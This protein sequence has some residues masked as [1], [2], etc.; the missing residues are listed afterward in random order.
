[1]PD[2]PRNRRIA[3]EPGW[4]L[5]ID[6]PAGVGVVLPGCDDRSDLLTVPIRSG[7]GLRIAGE[8]RLCFRCGPGGSVYHPDEA[9]SLADVRRI[10]DRLPFVTGYDPADL[11]PAVMAA[12]E[13]E[14]RAALEAER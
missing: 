10:A 9:Y 1:M 14:L 5:P 3:P 4:H 13:A 11:T 2:T 6:P 7:V 12:Y 8:A